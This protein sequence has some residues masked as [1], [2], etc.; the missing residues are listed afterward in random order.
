MLHRFTWESEVLD[1]HSKYSETSCKLECKMKA[2]S[3]KVD[4]LN[5]TISNPHLR[6]VAFLGICLK[7]LENVSV[8]GLHFCIGSSKFLFFSISKIGEFREVMERKECPLCL[9]DCLDINYHYSLSMT[10]IM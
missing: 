10:E 3:E 1:F 8:G 7:S 4:R 6:W 9:P 2:A 5:Q